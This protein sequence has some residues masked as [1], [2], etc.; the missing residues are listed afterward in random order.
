MKR[1]TRKH[2]TEKEVALMWERARFEVAN[3]FVAS[4]AIVLAYSAHR[5]E[6]NSLRSNSFS[7]D[8]MDIGMSSCS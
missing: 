5:V 6:K 4:I 1:K 2:Y 8:P 3:S 7:T